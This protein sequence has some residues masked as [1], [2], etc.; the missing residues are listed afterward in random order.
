VESRASV[1]QPSWAGPLRAADEAL[2]Q[3]NVQGAVQAWDAAHLAAAGSLQWDGLVEV[4]DL[5]LRIGE[6]SGSRDTT[7]ATTRRA[8]FAALFRACQTESLE[9]ILRVADAFA[10]LGDAQVVEEC[11]TLA[12]L[13]AGDD[14]AARGRVAGFVRGLA[15]RRPSTP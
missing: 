1:T 7:L 3:G 11:L 14:D 15:G 5:Y 2:A 12:R 10:R 8:Y 9:G 13:Q 4:G 6:A